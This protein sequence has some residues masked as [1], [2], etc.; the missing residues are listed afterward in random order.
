[1]EHDAETGEIEFESGRRLLSCVR[2]AVDDYGM[3]EEGD[4]ICV[5]LSCGKDSLA[6][7]CTLLMLRRFYPKSFTLCAVTID[8][9][10]EGMDFSAPERFCGECG[11]EYKIVRT[12]IS[13][14]IFNIRRESN[15]CSLCARM[16]R[17]TLHDAA[18]EMGANK[19][20]LGHHFDD[21][22]E[23]FM[24]NLFHEGRVGSFS[25]VT[26]LSRKELTMIRPM[27]YA[28]EKDVRYF[29][30]KNPGLPI[31]KNLCPEDEHTERETMKNM[32][33]QLDRADKGLKHRIFG[34][35]QKS[36]IDGWKE[37]GSGM[38]RDDER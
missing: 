26:Y 18:K 24:L 4:K 25:P 37:S 38:P 3:I 35:L 2:R 22:V 5:G 21:V 10:F 27:I 16:R 29:A 34:A 12:E 20:A 28:K 9:G 8:M 31:V 17:G 19:L 36:H 6:L 23:T 15:P 33:D 30:G 7:L 14:V 32:L 1:M 11:I 13:N